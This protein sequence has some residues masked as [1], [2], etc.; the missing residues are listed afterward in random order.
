MKK[1]HKIIA[2]ISMACLLVASLCITC[3]ADYSWTGEHGGSIYVPDAI[4]EELYYNPYGFEGGALT[5]GGYLNYSG[6]FTELALLRYLSYSYGDKITDPNYWQ[7]EIPLAD[8]GLYYLEYEL[9]LYDFN[10][11]DGY[12]LFN[13]LTMSVMQSLTAKET[14]KIITDDF[15]HGNSSPGFDCTLSSSESDN[16]YRLKVRHKFNFD[17]KTLITEL[18]D[19]NNVKYEVINS[20]EKYDFTKGKIRIRYQFKQGDIKT[21]STDIE[22][23]DLRFSKVE[24]ELDA[25]IYAALEDYFNK[26]ENDAY[27]SGLSVNSQYKDAYEDLSKDHENLQ[28]NYDN[29]MND[30][31]D[32]SDYASGLEDEVDN[33]QGNITYLEG[34]LETMEGKYNSA[35][36]GLDNSNAVMNFF[37]GIFDAVQGVLNT[38]FSLDVF[39]MNLGSIVAILL[40]AVIVIVVIKLFI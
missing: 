18:Y 28:T 7:Y 10:V 27:H 21:M 34:E 32:M 39:G 17:E 14:I 15:L 13:D 1:K 4:T 5:T 20:L 35:K 6:Y 19:A 16:I 38:F 36:E 37:Q 2:A 31:L 23:K 3:F 33:L 29:I 30:Y 8:S 40:G 26:I 24:K 12:T 9:L 11:W 25:D 22:C